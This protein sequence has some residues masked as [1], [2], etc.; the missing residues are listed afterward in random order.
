MKAS[1]LSVEHESDAWRG[2]LLSSLTAYMLRWSEEFETIDRFMQFVQREPACFERSTVEGHITAA[3]WLI[4]PA[5]ERVLLTHHRKLDKWLQLGGHADGCGDTR[6]VAMQEAQEES[7]IRD[8]RILSDDIFDI[9]IHPIPARS[10]DPAHLHFDVRYVFQA[11]SQDFTVS[12]ESHDL[13]WVPIDRIERYTTEESM[14]RMAKKWL[15]HW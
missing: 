13:A 11:L 6:A 3:A 2:Q 8:V 10:Q 14:K 9:D 4:D 12:H 5:S 1:I 7:G 15:T